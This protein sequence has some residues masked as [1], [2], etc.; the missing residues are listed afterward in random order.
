M[1]TLS[2]VRDKTNKVAALLIA[3]VMIQAVCAV[4]SIAAGPSE[5]NC[6]YANWQDQHSLWEISTRCDPTCM[7]A[8]DMQLPVH[9]FNN[10]FWEQSSEPDLRHHM[11]EQAAWSVVFVHGN[12]TEVDWSRSHSLDLFKKL[13]DRAEGPIRLI[14]LSWPSENPK[15]WISPSRQM[16]EKKSIVKANT[17]QLAYFLQRLGDGQPHGMIG[18]SLGAAVVAG[19]MHLNAGG[20]IGGVVLGESLSY[21]LRETLETR[22]GFVAPAFDRNALTANGEYCQMRCT[23]SSL[24]NLY[25]SRDPVMKRFR[26][27]DH[28]TTLAAGYLGLFETKYRPLQADPAAGGQILQ[29]D[30]RS[31]GATHA[32]KSYMCCCGFNTMIDNV[33]GKD[34]STTASV[35]ESFVQINNN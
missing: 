32:F 2:I 18:F 5:G 33:L 30:C 3:L 29:I 15:L 21:P 13:T 31:I 24:V 12:M 26:V 8:P 6:S 11:A 17:F 9:R 25:N 10:G 19:A 22:V 28:S 20:D 1:I 27:F 7:G 4:G 23:F 16:R 34:A 14:C 35:A